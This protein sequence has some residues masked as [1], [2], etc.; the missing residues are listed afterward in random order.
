[1]SRSFAVWGCRNFKIRKT[2]GYNPT[3][4]NFIDELHINFWNVSSHKLSYLDFGITFRRP[5]DDE[6]AS[7]GAICIFLPFKK[8]TDC[9]SDLS[10]N[11]ESS[12]NLV[13]AV[14][15]E[16]L[17]NR[18][19]VDER[20]LKLVLDNKGDLIINTKLAFK[21]SQLD[22]RVKINDAD[23]G[24]LIVFKLSDCLSDSQNCKH[25]IRFRINLNPSDLTNLVKT[26]YPK[27]LFLKSNIERSDIIDFRINEQRNL[28]SEISTTLASAACTPLKTHLF[29][30]RDMVDDCSASGSNY[31]GCRIL[32]SETWTKYFDKSVSFGPHDPMI[33]HWKI[34][35]SKESRLNDFSVVVKFKN[36]KAKIT[37]ILSYLLYGAAFALMLKFIPAKEV[38]IIAAIVSIITYISIHFWK[39]RK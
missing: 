38:Y 37:K 31:K 14:F 32:E 25:Y 2:S 36:T 22:Q 12:K 9:F 10:E 13:T 39:Y 35:N 30:I 18:E 15:N 1:M 29:I 23:D 4:S 11:L 34:D 24:T 8:S 6:I 7:N 26:F 33:Y 5:E 20:H 16:Y 27:D 17:I 3:H 19:T 28:P 21:N